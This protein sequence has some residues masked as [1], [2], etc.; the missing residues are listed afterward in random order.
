MSNPRRMSTAVLVLA[1]LCWSAGS[2]WAVESKL[3]P[4]NTEVVFTVNVRQI[5]ESEVVKAQKDVI[6]SVKQTLK[7]QLPIDEQIMKYFEEVGFDPYKHLIS[8]T[9]A[10]SGTGKGENAL[11]L[12]RGDFDSAKF[13]AAAKKGAQDHADVLKITSI[14]QIPVY[15][16]RADNKTVY[17]ALYQ[18]KYLLAS[19]N[20][21]SFKETLGRVAGAGGPD[22]PK[23][24]TLLATT[25]DKQSL[26]VVVTGN[27]MVALAKKVNAD[28]K[29][30][31]NVGDALE[32]IS[33]VLQSVEGASLAVTMAQDI[34]FQLGIGTKNEAAARD[35]VDNGKVALSFVNLWVAQVAKGEPSLAPLVDVAKTLQIRAD[36]SNVVMSGV[37]SYANLDK[38]IKAIK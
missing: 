10:H 20:Q 29:L 24:K 36:G 13:E 4:A 19:G 8:V 14:N 25:N 21:D 9:V 35:L 1:G 37:V 6:E 12:I 34:N 16:V 23:V 26:S 3:L 30:P 11:L 15:E 5:L 31:K 27:A 32:Q 2:G 7:G 17:V 28:P 18:G 38:L 22:A 33:E